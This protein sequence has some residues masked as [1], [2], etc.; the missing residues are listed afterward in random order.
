MRSVWPMSELIEFTVLTIAACAAIIS[1]AG[2]T[3][4]PVTKDCA[5][6]AA[7]SSDTDGILKA[8]TVV[9]IALEIGF[10]N[11]APFLIEFK[12]PEKSDKIQPPQNTLSEPVAIVEPQATKSPTLPKLTPFTNTVA[13][14]CASVES[15]VE[16]HECSFH[17]SPTRCA[18]IVFIK[19]L[20][21]PVKLGLGA[22][23]P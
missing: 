9:E 10:V 12:I 15:W 4:N 20:S 1:P 11:P 18:G 3:G 22:K 23:H 14:P 13:D 19:T 16:T 8:P 21:E 7:W 5:V 17:T 2:G 6:A